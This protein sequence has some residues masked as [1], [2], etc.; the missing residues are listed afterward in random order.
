[1]R[2]AVVA[3]IHGNILALEAVLA[4]LARRGGADL[5]VNLGDLV[6]GPLWPGETAA[7]LQALGWPTVRGNHD[8][9]VATDPLTEMGP[10]DRFAHARLTPAQRDWLEA[11][12]LTLEIAPSVLAFHARP[13]HDERYLSEVIDEGQLIRAPL[14]VIES[15][16]RRTA[17][18]YRLLLAGHSHRAD[19]VQL[20]DGRLLFN[21]GSVGIPAYSDDTAPAHVSEQG[22]PLARYGLVELDEA[23]AVAGIDALAVPYDHEAAARRAEEGGR[24]EWAHALRTGFMPD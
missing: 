14:K 10:S 24:P 13:D 18:E 3:D 19:L 7:R 6:S 12:P 22:S 20:A 8:R 1:M 11:L 16:L 4:D 17:P 15:R 9:R 5:V 23:G 2:I 21:P